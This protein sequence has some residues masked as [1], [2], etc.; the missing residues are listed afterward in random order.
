M[1]TRGELADGC[2][3]PN[4]KRELPGGEIRQKESR[5]EL[6]G[7]P[8]VEEKTKKKQKRRRMKDN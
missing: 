4:G 1:F 2:H 6:G 8:G 7:I 3:M 5:G